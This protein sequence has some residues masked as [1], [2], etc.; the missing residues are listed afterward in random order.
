MSKWTRPVPLSYHSHARLRG[1]NT[2]NVPNEFSRV[3]KLTNAVLDRKFNTA[4]EKNE[5]EALAKRFDIAKI[6]AFTLE[7][8]IT[9]KTD[10]PGA[11]DLVA[12]IKSDVVKFVVDGKDESVNIDENFDVVLLTEDMARNNYE[13]L[14]DFDIEIFGA[15][16]M[17][18][19]GEIAAQYLS[20]C[21]FM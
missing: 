20:L 16:R 14:R 15:D 13:Q 4:A 9:E 10:S 12:T 3:V 11:Y 17:V 8:I 18:D 19:V 2:V 7:Y 6:R 1:T 21:I 5:L